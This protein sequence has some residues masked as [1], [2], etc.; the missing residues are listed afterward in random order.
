MAASSIRESAI[1]FR[2]AV[3]RTAE[4]H[5]ILYGLSNSA[6]SRRFG[7]QFPVSALARHVDY[8]RARI[9]RGTFK[10]EGQIWVENYCSRSRVA[11][12]MCSTRPTGL[13]TKFY[14]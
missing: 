8:F 13:T 9:T 12:S 5:A 1:E 2:D 10:Y 6:G 14:S 3:Y 7:S 4:R 11:A